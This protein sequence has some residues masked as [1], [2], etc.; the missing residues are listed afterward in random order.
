[1]HSFHEEDTHTKKFDARV[2]RQLL[3]YLRPHFWTFMYCLLILSGILAASLLGPKLT[4]VCIDV[5]IKAGQFGPLLLVASG[6]LVIA[7]L[8][9]VLNWL[10]TKN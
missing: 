7:L 10:L 8:G 9:M 4:Q 1:M 5:Y 2:L 6:F 3:P